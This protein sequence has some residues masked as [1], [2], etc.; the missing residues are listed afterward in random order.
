MIKRPFL[1]VAVAAGALL[2]GL[3][4]SLAQSTRTAAAQQT[5]LTST[6]DAAV[7]HPAK[8][9]TLKVQGAE[10]YYEVQGAGPTLLIIAGGPQD[11]GVF[12]DLSQ[13]LADRYTVV[14]YDPRG[15]S[16]S[17]FDG[18]PEELSLDVQAD[19]AA[20]LLKALGGGP[21]YVFGTS[22]GAQIGLNLA[23]R[24][25]ELVRALVAHEPPSMMLMADPSAEVSAAQDLYDTYRS[26]GVEA[27]MGKFF[28]DNGLA[29][30]TKPQEAP[31]EFAMPPEDMETF[32]RVS[33]NFE[34]WLAHGMRPLSFYRPD[35]VA[36][37]A[38]KPLV[39]V[40]IG[41]QSAGQPIERMGMALAEKLGTELVIF[42]GDHFGFQAL[43]Q[44]FATTLHQ[45]LGGK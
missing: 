37:R 41:E 18:A 1:L 2:S 12:A 34:Y 31:P 43:A 24:H 25:P 23:V 30:E 29:D 15:N 28:G 10:I 3:Q 33:G 42:P 11:A 22:G 36:L 38:G 32:A 27:A 19:D 35:V 45:A 40:G 16:R 8:S 4:P 14:A 13:H 17:A 6:G 26:D 21:A 9:S 7:T 20:A 39:I 5:T 44:P